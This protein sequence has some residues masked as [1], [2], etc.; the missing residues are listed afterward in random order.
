MK[1]LPS[2]W[3]IKPVHAITMGWSVEL[4]F[5][6]MEFALSEHRLY[7]EIYSKKDGQWRLISAPEKASLKDVAQLLEREA[8]EMLKQR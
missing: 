4:T 8:E 7:L 2:G 5:K 6:N 3:A 1:Y